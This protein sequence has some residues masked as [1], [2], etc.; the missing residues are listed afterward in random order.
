MDGIGATAPPLARGPESSS[1]P[2]PS[3]S[4]DRKTHGA[5]ADFE[6]LLLAQ[7]LKS[8]PMG[9]AEDDQAGGT[10]L[11]FAREHLAGALASQ[12]GLGIAR[13]VLEGLKPRDGR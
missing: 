5:A 6:A 3:G 11:D 12:G 10:M 8:V 9:A 13:L 7:M 2:R 1:E 4:A